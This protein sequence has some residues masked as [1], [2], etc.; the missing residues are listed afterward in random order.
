[1][2]VFFLL[3]LPHFLKV[4]KHK[5]I[6]IYIQLSHPINDETYPL[7]QCNRAGCRFTRSVHSCP[8]DRN[9]VQLPQ[10]SWAK[11]IITTIFTI[12]S[13]IKLLL[14]CSAEHSL[15]IVFCPSS[16]QHWRKNPAKHTVKIRNDRFQFI[17]LPWSPMPW[18]PMPW[19]MVPWWQCFDNNPHPLIRS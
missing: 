13:T 2:P 11:N 18:S 8:G 10:L 3:I 14:S 5:S 12:N 1:M 19:K 4:A 6:C 17:S 16:L 9:H 15:W 7:H